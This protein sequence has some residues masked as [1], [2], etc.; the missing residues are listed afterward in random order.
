MEQYFWILW[1]LLGVVFITAEVFTLGFVLLWFGIG[2]VV[3]AIAASL[4]VGV[5]GQ[6]LIFSAVSTILTVMSRTIFESVFTRIGDEDMKMGIDRL[7]GRIGTVKIASKGALNAASVKVY[8]STWK[9]FPIDEETEL[10]KG[11]KVE[12]V[13]VEGSSIYVRKAKNE[14]PGWRKE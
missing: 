10:S 12:V 9:A 13:R 14:L 3:A 8:G 7:P 1:A 6:F 2:A 5:L 11:E 4:G